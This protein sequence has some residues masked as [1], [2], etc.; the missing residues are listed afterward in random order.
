MCRSRARTMV[1]REYAPAPL[2]RLGLY[3]CNVPVMQIDA[4]TFLAMLRAGGSTVLAILFSTQIVLLERP[5]LVEQ[6]GDPVEYVRAHGFA[7][8]EPNVGRYFTAALPDPNAQMEFG[9]PVQNS[10]IMAFEAITF[11]SSGQSMAVNIVAGKGPGRTYV[12]PLR[13]RLPYDLVRIADVPSQPKEEAITDVSSGTSA[14]VIV[15]STPF[16]ST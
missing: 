10:H 1:V 2:L 14:R 6:G 5:H 16:S 7:N 15:W 8:P 13:P 12:D 3:S 11:S 9:E 4:S